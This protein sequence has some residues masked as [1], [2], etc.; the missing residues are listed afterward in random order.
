MSE[1][2]RKYPRTHHIR[3]SRL[4]PGDEDLQAVPFA[5]LRRRHLAVEEKV[6]GANAGLSFDAQ[7]RLRLQSRGHFLVGGPRETHFDLFKQWG[8]SIADLLRPVLRQ[9][10]VLYGEWLYAKHTIF[11]DL[12]PEYFLEFDV[13]DLQEDRFLSTP[14]RR[15]LLAGL[16]IHSVPVLHEGSVQSL[17]DLV[18]WIG[19]SAFISAEHRENLREQCRRRQVD[20]ERVQ[21]ETDSVRTMEGLYVK[22]EEN[23]CV[24]ERFKFIR[25]GFLTSVV[26]SESHW[27]DRPIVPNRLDPSR[28]VP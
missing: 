27:L 21:R 26:E 24:M 13:L 1:R 28:R 22:V 16:P 25:P 5:Q 15:E 11:Y 7:G 2:I 6:D 20:H 4:Q 18:K 3:G 10:Y 19:D 17:Q 23:G 12:L 8:Q 9:R 14:R